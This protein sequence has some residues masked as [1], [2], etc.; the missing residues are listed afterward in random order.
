MLVTD[1]T[2]DEWKGLI[3][4]VYGISDLLELPL[5]MDKRG[6]IEGEA[7]RIFETDCGSVKVS[8]E[9]ISSFVGSKY[10]DV[11]VILKVGVGFNLA[12]L[13]RVSKDAFFI[14]VLKPEK[15]YSG[16]WEQ[17][18]LGVPTSYREAIEP[19][20]DSIVETYVTRPK[21]K[22]HRYT[23]AVSALVSKV[24]PVETSNGQLQ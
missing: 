15:P 6:I 10:K 11:G 17:L 21:S 20:L 12:V 14:H 5:F 2:K 4:R 18:T 7:D 8:Y 13:W 3:S 19:L 9:V 22:W 16:F 24:L 1:F 23:G